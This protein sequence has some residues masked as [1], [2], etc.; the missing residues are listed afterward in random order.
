[1]SDK[2]SWEE[3]AITAARARAEQESRS[4]WR[5]EG[6]PPFNYRWEHLKAVV[7]IAETLAQELGADRDVVRAAAWLHDLAKEEIAE[8]RDSHGEASAQE[9]KKILEATDFPPEKIPRV[10]YAIAQHVGLFRDEPLQN[11]ETAI[12]WDADKLSKLGATSLVHYLMTNP[13]S[14]PGITT[15]RYFAQYRDWLETAA[16]IVSSMNTPPGRKMA[17]ERYQFMQRFYRQLAQELGQGG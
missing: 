11:L 16:R 10:M 6:T 14:V 3:V 4:L 17:E 8:G 2:K 13:A 9:A 1:M 5:A 15:E 7:A 12:I